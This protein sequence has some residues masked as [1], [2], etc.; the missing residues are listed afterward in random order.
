[1]YK[2]KKES[3]RVYG[4]LG[5]YI[6]LLLSLAQGLLHGFKLSSFKRSSENAVVEK[7]VN[8]QDI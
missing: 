5:F 8:H 2:N 6:L 1:M 7:V 3:E 4:E